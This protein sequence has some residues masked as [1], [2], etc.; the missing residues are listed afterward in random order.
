VSPW[1]R[2]ILVVVFLLWSYIG[3]VI[4]QQTYTYAT[5]FSISDYSSNLRDCVFSHENATLTANSLD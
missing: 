3:L 5:C 1:L 4:W 2:S